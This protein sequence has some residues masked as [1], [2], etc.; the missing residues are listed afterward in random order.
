MIKALRAAM[1]GGLVLAAACGPAEP[2]KAAVPAGDAALAASLQER[3][4]DAKPGDVIALPAGKLA[5]DRGLSLAVDRVTLKGAGPDA[6]ILSFKGQRAGAEG[7]LITADGVTIEAL[8]IEDTKGDGLK[9][10]ECKDVVIRNVRVEWTAGPRT[11]NG[12]YG[13]YPVKCENVLIEDSVAIAASDAGIYVGQSKNAVVRRNKA[14]RNV[15]GIEIENTVSA[16]VYENEAKDNT[17]GVLVFNMPHLE[18][19]TQNVRVFKNV[20]ES[21]NLKNFAAK[22][23][24]VASVPAG[25][26]VIVQAADQIEIFDNDIADNKTANI[27]VSSYFSAN[28]SEK[29]EESATFDPYPE[30]I[31]IYANRFRGG[32]ANPDNLELQALRIAMFGPAGRIP[33]VLWDGY[34]DP[35]KRV[36]GALPEA[37]RICLG[38]GPELLDVDGPNGY[39]APRLATPAHR[40]AHAALPA[41]A[42]AA[43]E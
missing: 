4:I 3:L 28:Y 32:G 37:L 8:A 30:A 31:H 39:K 33:D 38:E 35:A 2:H 43:G 17:G 10:N 41:V 26:G 22:G 15:A 36:D 7:L 12:A 40:C 11:E 1:L 16:D 14:Y 29:F 13:L 6:T 9:A 18:Q 24:A 5:F 27:I 19:P 20:I 21:N 42:L 34:A 23:T 25:S